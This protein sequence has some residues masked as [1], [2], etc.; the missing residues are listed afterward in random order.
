MGAT[1]AWTTVNEWESKNDENSNSVMTRLFL[2]LNEQEMNMAPGTMP[3]IGNV[4]F[5][6][7]Q[8][9]QQ[10]GGRALQRGEPD[11]A[12]AVGGQVRVPVLRAVEQHGDG[13]MRPRAL[14]PPPTDRHVT[15]EPEC[16]IV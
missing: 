16:D 13:P 6:L 11:P 4:S 8:P 10:R 14:M 2:Q 15:D 5:S 7:Q 12:L 9:L 3:F 1:G